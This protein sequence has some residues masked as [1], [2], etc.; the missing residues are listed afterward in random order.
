MRQV[1]SVQALKRRAYPSATLIRL[2]FAAAGVSRILTV[3]ERA[4]NCCDDAAIW[5][6]GGAPLRIW[7][8]R[9]IRVL[10][11]NLRWSSL[12]PL[13][14]VARQVPGGALAEGTQF[15]PTWHRNG[16]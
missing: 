10:R 3:F 7:F 11:R 1:G 12:I 13:L 4:A 2:D 15:A 16:P 6:K 9:A 8:V 5:V 14:F